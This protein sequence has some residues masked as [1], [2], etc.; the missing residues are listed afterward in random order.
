MTL[1]FF[2][3]KDTGDELIVF[4][5]DDEPSSRPGQILISLVKVKNKA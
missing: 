5:A 1:S 2:L 4:A 3:I